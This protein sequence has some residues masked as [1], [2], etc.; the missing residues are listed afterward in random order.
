MPTVTTSRYVYEWC[1]LGYTLS[2]LHSLCLF[3]LVCGMC[4]CVWVDTILVLVVGCCDIIMLLHSTPGGVMTHT[5][6]HT[7]LKHCS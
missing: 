1:L 3:V 7:S 5:L 2:L 4:T 6:P